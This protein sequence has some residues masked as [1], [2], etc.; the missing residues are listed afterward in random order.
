MEVT[1]RLEHEKLKKFQVFNGAQLKYIAFLSMLIDH[2][3]NALIIPMLNGERLLL[4]VSNLFSVLG[5]IAFP[6]FIFFIVEGFFKTSSRKRYLITL[7]AFGMISEVPFDMFTSKTFFSPYWNNMMFTLALCL[8]TIWMID[9]LKEK[10]SNKI[11]WHIVSI[12]V[13][14]IC[15]AVAMALSLDYDYHAIIV[16]Y[17]FYIFYDRPVLGAVLGY[18]SIIKEL[19][20]FFG[21]G[22]VLTYN[23]ERGR[24]Y[25]WFNYLFYPLHILILGMLRFYFN[26]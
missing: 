20:S 10:I 19:Y 1:K 2:T 5:R 26:I 22:I 25:K 12:V 14:A 6:V 18:L 21:F 3:N 23:R 16:A 7:L 4:H 9:S 13:V 24:Q 15:S 11:V 8:I 17:L